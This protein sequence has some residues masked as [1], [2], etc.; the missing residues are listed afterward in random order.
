MTPE[1]GAWFHVKILSSISKED[2]I[3][4]QHLN[5]SRNNFLVNK[6][7][8]QEDS[9]LALDAEPRRPTWI[10]ALICNMIEIEAQ[11]NL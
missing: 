3:M 7:C 9:N 11:L 2:F 8:N 6:L 4:Q 10:L 1:V 5:I